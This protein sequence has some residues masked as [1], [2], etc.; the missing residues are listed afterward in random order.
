MLLPSPVLPAQV[1]VLIC[2]ELA[3]GE[4][5]MTGRGR[6]YGPGLEVAQIALLTAHWVHLS[7]TA[8]GKGGRE[9]SSSD[10]PRR[11]GNEF[12]EQ[13]SSLCLKY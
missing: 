12:G 13:F 5:A 2:A 9:M 3:K 4:G 1:T 6:A 7:H 10:V 11:R 8:T